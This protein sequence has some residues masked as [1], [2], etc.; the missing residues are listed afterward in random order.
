MTYTVADVSSKV[1]YGVL[2][3]NLAQIISKSEGYFYERL[4]RTDGDVP[5]RRS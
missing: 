1:I 4:G 3:T 2:L 5:V